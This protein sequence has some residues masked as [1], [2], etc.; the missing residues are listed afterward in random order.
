MEYHFILVEPAVPEN[1]GAAARAIKTMGFSNLRLVKP[2]NHLAKEAKWLAHGSN[3]VLTDAKLY[4]SLEEATSDID[5]LIAT[6][7]KKRSSKF[8]YYSPEE[9]LE[10]IK[11][12]DNTIKS[13]GIIFGREESGLTNLELKQCDIAATVP[14]KAPYPSINLAQSVMIFAYV[15]SNVNN[16]STPTNNNTG[17][18]SLLKQKA[19]ELLNDIDIKENNNLNGRIMERIALLNESDICLV[20]SIL[21]RLGK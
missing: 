9:S 1:I 14:L 3:E 12:K 16:L 2:N 7:A 5:F 17:D 4:A 21:N 6:T 18:Y 19:K 11:N 20:L 8:D 15:F 13:V 10:I